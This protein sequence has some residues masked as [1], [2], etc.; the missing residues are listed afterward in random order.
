MDLTRRQFD[1]PGSEK[2][3]N[4]VWCFADNQDTCLRIPKKGIKKGN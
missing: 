4:L 2:C 3:P 1:N